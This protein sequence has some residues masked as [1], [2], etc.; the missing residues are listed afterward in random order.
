M[1]YK[2]GPQRKYKHICTCLFRRLEETLIDITLLLRE[3]PYYSNRFTFTQGPYMSWGLPQVAFCNTIE[4]LIQ[5]LETLLSGH[6]CE[7]DLGQIVFAHSVESG[8]ELE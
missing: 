8:P 7:K 2:S 1:V 6:F 4:R 5:S 3:V